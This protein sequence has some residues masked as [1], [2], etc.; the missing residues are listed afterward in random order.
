MN[1]DQDK[2]FTI[3]E[4]HNGVKLLSNYEMQLY[5]EWKRKKLNERCERKMKELDLLSLRKELMEK[6]DELN[7]EPIEKIE[8]DDPDLIKSYKQGRNNGIITGILKAI[9]IIREYE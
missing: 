1:Y 2:Y 3:I 6:I 4:K 9:E 7:S 8:D 5:K